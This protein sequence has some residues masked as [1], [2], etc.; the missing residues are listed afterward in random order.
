M[1]EFEDNLWLSVVREHRD[2]LAR[3][4][5][6]VHKHGRPPRPQLLAGT[7]VGLAAMATAA[8][9][10]LGAS[11]SSPAFA[12]TRNPDGT[13]TV[14]LMKLSG[15]AG[16]RK[17]R[18]DGRAGAD[19]GCREAPAEICLPGRYRADDHVRPGEH[20]QAPSSGDHPWPTELRR[21]RGSQGQHRQRQ[22]WQHG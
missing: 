18:G 19:P 21:R 3:T 8:A 7:T 17:A 6:T 5:G 2:E 15:I 14:D 22:H 4:G 10:L 13:V 11:T 16:Q 9:L 20:P 12:V 1:S